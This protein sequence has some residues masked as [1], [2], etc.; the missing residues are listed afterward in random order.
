MANPV[1]LF[2]EAR[3]LLENK[4]VPDAVEVL[5]RIGKKLASSRS[6]GLQRGKTSN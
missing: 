3:E 1:A 6:W 4:S 5:N 2:G